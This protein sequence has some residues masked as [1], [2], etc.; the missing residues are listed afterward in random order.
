MNATQKI[1]SILKLTVFISTLFIFLACED[2]D[3][4]TNSAPTC[5]ITSPA[6]STTFTLGGSHNN[7]CRS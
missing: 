5:A 2:D 1:I 7:Q 6:D 3:E 4:Y